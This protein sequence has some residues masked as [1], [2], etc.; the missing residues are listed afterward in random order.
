MAA[1]KKG[2]NGVSDAVSTISGDLT[3]EGSVKS[4]GEVQLGGHI[5]G[6]IHAKRLVVGKEAEVIGNVISEE[7][8]IHGHVAGDIRADKVQLCASSLVE[9]TIL[10]QTI[11]IETGARFDGD[12]RHFSSRA[13]KSAPKDA[14][15][16][17]DV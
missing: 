14:A 12:C 5:K 1:Y 10:H 9:G 17:T 7:A 3:I 15:T 16:H 11:S 2:Y 6:D 13:N 8:I 4:T